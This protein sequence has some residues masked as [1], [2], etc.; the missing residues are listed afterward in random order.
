MKVKQKEG[1]EGGGSLGL[2]HKEIYFQHN[3]L[4]LKEYVLYKQLSVGLQTLHHFVLIATC[5]ISPILF[6]SPLA[7]RDERPNERVR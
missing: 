2:R 1:K 7:F 4:N 5:A 6:F 3:I